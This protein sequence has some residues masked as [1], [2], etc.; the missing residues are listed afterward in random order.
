M[1]QIHIKSCQDNVDLLAGIYNSDLDVETKERVHEIKQGLY[2]KN[3]IKQTETAILVIEKLVNRN[4]I[5][6]VIELGKKA[7]TLMSFIIRTVF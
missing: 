5:D 1:A 7:G 4:A 2:D 6:N 3:F